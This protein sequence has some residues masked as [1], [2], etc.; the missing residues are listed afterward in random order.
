M[1]IASLPGFTLPGDISASD[2]FYDQDITEPFVLEDGDYIS[3]RWP[4]DAY[5]L[6]RRLLARLPAPLT[7]SGS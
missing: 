1:A 2:R 3:A 5:L 7:V 4:G 6:G